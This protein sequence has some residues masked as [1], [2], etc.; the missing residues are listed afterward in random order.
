M[1]NLLSY[2][3]AVH[4]TLQGGFISLT[5]L[6][7]GHQGNVL[8]SVMQSCCFTHKSNNFVMLSLSLL[9]K[10]SINK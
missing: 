4:K 10:L 5:Y 6:C 1:E 8:K 3:Q 2:F 9:L 7:S